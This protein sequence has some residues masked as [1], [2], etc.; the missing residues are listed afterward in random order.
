MGTK[1]LLETPRPAGDRG[2]HSLNEM[3][4]GAPSRL[5]ILVK[6]SDLDKVL[7]ALIIANGA[8]AMEMPVTIFFAFWDINAL[9]R[10]ELA[11]VKTGLV[12]RLFGAM[13]PRGP[14]Q[15]KLPRLNM[16]GMESFMVKR[17]MKSRNFYS[18]EQLFDMAAQNG[19]EFITCIMS[20]G[21]MGIRKRGTERRRESRGDGQVPGE[22]GSGKDPPD[23]LT[24]R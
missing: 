7:A 14:R 12:D 16:A 22:C 13:M 17:A 20:M 10:E 3:A 11:R 2:H 4:E 8:V 9:R 6:S 1:A 18:L 21:M 19:V 23:L 15:L 24:I 5:S